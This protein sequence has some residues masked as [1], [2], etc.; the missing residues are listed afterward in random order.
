MATGK[1]GAKGVEES[2][3]AKGAKPSAKERPAKAPAANAGV[4]APRSRADGERRYWLLKSE[5][6]AFSFDDLL[7]AP[8]RTTCWDGVRNYQARNFL[9]DEMRPGDLVLFYHSGAEPS[10]AGTAEV[11]RG[12]YPDHTAFD[13]DDA[14]FDAK[15]RPDLP[16]WYMVDVRAL[17]RFAHPVA[18]VT[19][20][21]TPGLEGMALLQRGSRLSVQP[22]RPT[23][24]EIVLGL[25]RAGR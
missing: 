6:D 10:V 9:R 14:H 24:F 4:A 21:S 1:R 3:G 2:K 15:S 13:S 18:L 25:G 16:T 11:V 17:E 22:V 7:A 20:R 8:A 19:L 5:P 23:E 12:G